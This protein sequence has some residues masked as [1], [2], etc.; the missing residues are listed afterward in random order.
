MVKKAA[1]KIMDNNMHGDSFLSRMYREGANDKPPAR[2]DAAILSE[3]RKAVSA[4]SRPRWSV[5]LWVKPMSAAAVVVL[6]VT[7]V[8]FMA[9]EGAVP[10]P[11]PAN[12][13]LSPR[14]K[15]AA[16]IAGEPI[17]PRPAKTTNPAPKAPV[18]SQYSKTQVLTKP[19]TGTDAPPP[20]TSPMEKIQQ[21]SNTRPLTTAQRIAPALAAGTAAN[22]DVVSVK[23]SGSA[24]AYRFLVTV[25]SPDIGCERY[26]DWWELVGEDGR[27]WYRLVLPQSHV[28][29][30]PFTRESGPITIQPDVVVWI[31]AH[32][33]SSGYG[34]AAFKGS[35]R[36][37]FRKAELSPTFAAELAK[38]GPLPAGCNFK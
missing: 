1:D 11:A 25:R 31:R 16:P 34:G 36:A 15:P 32:M 2:L 8:M 35:A 24:G 3:A 17:S 14:E 21:Y 20:A 12:P 28:N 6:S 19:Q 7:L 10:L 5:S 38:R 29:E 13:G 27:L 33:H 4:S 18:V 23:V 9:Y 22:A 26:A 37:G 30:Q